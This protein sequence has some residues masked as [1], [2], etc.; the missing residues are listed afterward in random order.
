MK[1]H[2]RIRKTIKFG[3]AALTV[4]LVV[5]WAWSMFGPRCILW[6]DKLNAYLRPGGI[7]VQVFLEL[8]DPEFADPEFRRLRRKV[9]IEA[10]RRGPYLWTMDGAFSARHCRVSIPLWP[11]VAASALATALAFRLDTLARR[12]ARM[13]LCAKCHYDRTGLAGDAVCPECGTAPSTPS[14]PQRGDGL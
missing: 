11:L 2:P 3:G 8:P 6:S 14:S 12:R 4:L 13:H 10:Y 9:L 1:P 5:V 7:A